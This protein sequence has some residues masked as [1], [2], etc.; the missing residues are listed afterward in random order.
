MI[1]Y[2][3]MIE[4]ICADSVAPV[5][6][7]NLIFPVHVSGGCFFLDSPVKK[8]GTKHFQCFCLVFK[9]TAFILA[10]N[11]GAGR[12]MRNSHSAVCCVDT[13]SSM[14]GSMKHID[15]QF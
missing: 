5:S 11:N 2:I 1:H 13:L 8:P 7:A 6:P 10:G 9:L 3:I 4:I 14:T 12:K 15:T